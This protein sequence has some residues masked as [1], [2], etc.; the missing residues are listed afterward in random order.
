MFKSILSYSF[1]ILTYS[2]HQ[3]PKLAAKEVEND[4][5]KMTDVKFL[6]QRA[7]FESVPPD[8]LLIA[9]YNF[10]NIG[11]HDLYIDDISPDCSCTGYLLS[12]R[13]VSPGDSAYIVLKYSTKEKFGYSKVYA[14]VSANT[15]TR[16]YSL[17]IAASV[18]DQ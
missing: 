1:L 3:T 5:S 7:I 17:E 4:S 16:L 18:R 2:C 14:T 13:K 11:K 10:I 9:R 15:P 12:K 8:T 6:E